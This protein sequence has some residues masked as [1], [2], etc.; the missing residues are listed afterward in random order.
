MGDVSGEV[1]QLGEFKKWV[2]D[3]VSETSISLRDPIFGNFDF[4][5]PLC[6]LSNEAISSK[7]VSHQVV[8]LASL[9]IFASYISRKYSILVEMEQKIT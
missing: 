4:C 9:N 6:G 1:V 7:K 8:E 5:P 2:T 3:L